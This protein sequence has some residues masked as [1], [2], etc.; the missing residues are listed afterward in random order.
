MRGTYESIKREVMA[1]VS[2]NPSPFLVSKL[3]AAVYK[4][5]G[6][7]GDQREAKIL[8]EKIRRF[9]SELKRKQP[10]CYNYMIS[11]L[12]IEI[13]ETQGH[14]HE[15][16]VNMD[17][18]P[19]SFWNWFLIGAMRSKRDDRRMLAYIRIYEANKM[20]LNRLPVKAELRKVFKDE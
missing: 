2:D 14:Y 3:L 8:A 20:K 1:N 9:I 18:M 7:Y 16:I 11:K 17:T 4:W 6:A 13:I 5:Q 15:L 12:A 10:Q 19:D